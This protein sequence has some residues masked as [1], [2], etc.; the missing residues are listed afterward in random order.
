[1]MSLPLMKILMTSVTV[2]LRNPMIM[3]TSWMRE[4]VMSSQKKRTW[5]SL[6]MVWKMMM[7]MMMKNRMKMK[8]MLR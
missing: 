5:R 8:I 3:M 1:M 6:K 4:V 2:L 7:M